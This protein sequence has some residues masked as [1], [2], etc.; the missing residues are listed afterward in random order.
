[1]NKKDE[2][3]HKSI[4]HD[5]SE[6]VMIIGLDGITRYIN[7][8]AAVILGKKKRRISQEKRSPPYFSMMN[9]MTCLIKL[10]WMPLRMLLPHIIISYLIIPETKPKPYMS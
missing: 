1:M 9:A 10:Y 2:F 8:A 5:M 7:P 4:L 6:G 3:I